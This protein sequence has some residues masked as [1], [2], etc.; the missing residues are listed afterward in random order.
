VTC[1]SIREEKLAFRIEFLRQSDRIGLIFADWAIV[2]FG[3]FFSNHGRS[4]IFGYF[5]A[6][7]V[8]IL[9]NNGLGNKLGDFFK[10]LIWSPCSPVKILQRSRPGRGHQIIVSKKCQE[11]FPHFFGCPGDD[12]TIKNFRRL[13]TIFEGKNNLI[14]R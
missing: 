11:K 5:K 1:H 3:Q 14:I 7:Y 9:T 6:M 13:L 4:T 12:A 8:F 10:K 2:F